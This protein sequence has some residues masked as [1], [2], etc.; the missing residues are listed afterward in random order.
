M[1]D[2]QACLQA[3]RITTLFHIYY[4]FYQFFTAACALHFAAVFLCA[5]ICYNI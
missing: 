2:I 4:K 1:R 3:N 5:L